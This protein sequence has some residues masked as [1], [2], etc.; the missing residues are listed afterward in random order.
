[1]TSFVVTNF[2]DAG[3]GSLHDFLAAANANA[4]GNTITFASILLGG[5]RVF[6]PLVN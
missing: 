4:D 5:T 3:A 2:N 6:S 1:M